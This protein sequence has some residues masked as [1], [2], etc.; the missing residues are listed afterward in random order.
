MPHIE[1]VSFSQQPHLRGEER[2]LE[3]LT[4]L[5][6]QGTMK[7][8]FKRGS[9]SAQVT[10]SRK[11]FLTLRLDRLSPLPL[12]A[13][14]FT[15]CHRDIIGDLVSHKP[16]SWRPGRV[17]LWPARLRVKGRGLSLV[18]G[19]VHR[20]TVLCQESGDAYLG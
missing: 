15:Y 6:S 19:C 12:R 5:H 11:P 2:R 4:M 3:R 14:L 10:S 16:V 13:P 9:D 17:W 1:H 18:V 20:G 7:P 8:Q